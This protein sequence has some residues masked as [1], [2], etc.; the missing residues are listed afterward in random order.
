MRTIILGLDSFDPLT[1]ERLLEQGRMPNLAR[2]VNQQAYASF[3]VPDPPQSEVSWTSIATG[4]NP[5]GHG[6]FDFVHRNPEN[7]KVF[8]SLLPT[9]SGLSG[10]RF[11][12]PFHANTI[13]DKVVSDG[14]PATSLWWPAMFPARHQSPVRSIPGLGTP[15]IR[16]RLGVGTIFITA[17][18]T[19][20]KG[21]KTAAQLLDASDLEHY[22]GH[23]LG[24]ARSKGGKTE[25]VILDFTLEKIDSNRVLLIIGKQILN[26]EVGQWSPI[27][28]LDFR[29]NWLFSV[30]A[31]T[32]LIVNQNRKGVSL[33]ALPLQIHPLKTPWPYGTPPRFVKQSW[34]N[35]GPFLTLG[36]P[37]DTTALEEGHINDKQFLQ[38]CALILEERQRVFMYHLDRFEEGLLAAVFDS[39][40]RIQHMF[41]RQRSDIVD[42]WYVKLD[43]FVGQIEQRLKTQ[44]KRKD[45]HLF[46]LSDHGF[47]R[48][49]HKVHLNRW[50]LEN[51]YLA[52]TGNATEGTFRQV[53]WAKTKAYALGLNSI[54][55]N[56]NGREGQGIVNSAERIVLLDE[57]GQKLRAWRG[58]GEGQVVSQVLTQ[59]EAFEGAMAKYG[60]DLLVGYAQGYRASQETGLGNWGQQ[61]IELNQDHWRADHCMHAAIVPGVLFAGQDTLRNFPRPS[62]RDIPAMTIGADPDQ[63]GSMP[64]PISSGDEDEHTVEERLRSLGYL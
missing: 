35:A 54:Y 34:R 55:L 57:L 29:V 31:V 48:F 41:L 59:K 23:F 19:V 2:Y 20:A 4:L 52:V 15:D 43:H 45:T 6:L 12:P 25:S 11:A 27:V 3:A 22:K 63:S 5:G 37:Q 47:G 51:G 17:S 39:L 36:W 9:K 8:V 28:E 16:G 58:P 64:P 49:D 40:D 10:T 26:L 14:Y 38:L 56:L 42:E 13:F 33:Y 21:N 53:N 30:K 32:R 62:Y 7:Y 1:F 61:S 46:I 44:G 50:L 24:P 18:E 60:P